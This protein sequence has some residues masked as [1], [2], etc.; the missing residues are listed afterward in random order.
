MKLFSLTKKT[1]ELE[2]WLNADVE[3]LASN[4]GRVCSHIDSHCSDV[5]RAV[6]C[7][8][9]VDCSDHLCNSAA[10]VTC[11]YSYGSSTVDGSSGGTWS[12]VLER[13]DG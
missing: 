11:S 9:A 5:I 2:K 6:E 1:N 8:F 10:G 4:P 12:T 3:C 13:D 7:K